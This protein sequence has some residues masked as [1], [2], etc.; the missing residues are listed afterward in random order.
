MRAALEHWPSAGNDFASLQ[1]YRIGWVSAL[2]VGIFALDHEKPG[3]AP[4]ASITP[5]GGNTSS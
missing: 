5:A 2:A 4:A 1:R 3:L